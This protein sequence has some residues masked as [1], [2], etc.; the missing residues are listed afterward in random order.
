[1]ATVPVARR[2]VLVSALTRRA[3]DADIL[4]TFSIPPW[5]EFRQVERRAAARTGI[6]QALA[7]S[8]RPR[9]RVRSCRDEAAPRLHVSSP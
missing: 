3:T 5:E 9:G 4:T 7:A 1:M 2:I 6:Q 8:V